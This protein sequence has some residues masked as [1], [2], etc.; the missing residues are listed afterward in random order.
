MMPGSTRVCPASISKEDHQLL[1]EKDK[2]KLK[3]GMWRCKHSQEPGTC[4]CEKQAC[5]TT[6]RDPCVFPFVYNGEKHTSCITKD[7]HQPWCATETDSSGNFV[8]WKWGDCGPACDEV[9]Y[10]HHAGECRNA[11]GGVGTHER[12][13]LAVD[14]C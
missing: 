13:T 3:Q 11:K 10:E 4:S 7:H 12:L 8:S 2:D 1:D 9:I 6:D 5:A 14:A